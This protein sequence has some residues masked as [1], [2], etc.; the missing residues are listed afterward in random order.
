MTAVRVADAPQAPEL[1]VARDLARRATWLVPVALLVGLVGW[2]WGG[3]A[4][5][6]F[7]LGLVTV[8]FLLAA[9]SMAW[10]ARISLGALMATVMVGYVVRLG[11]I[12]VATLAVVHA[13][14]FAPVPFGG[15]L[16]V[17]HL[18]LLLWETRYVSASL[19]YPGLKPRAKRGSDERD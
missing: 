17:A 4:S 8:N 2:G 12:V 3:A 5:A 11:V 19:A 7:A 14:W 6:L 15:T 16:I 10:A 1:D 13:A 9:A 18:A